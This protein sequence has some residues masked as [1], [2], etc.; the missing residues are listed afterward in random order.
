MTSW[1]ILKNG[2][3]RVYRRKEICARACK[4][5]W[6]QKALPGFGG[7]VPQGC[8]HVAGG[9][10]FMP[11]VRPCSHGIYTGNAG[12]KQNAL[13][14][15][16]VREFS[17]AARRRSRWRGLGSVIYPRPASLSAGPHAPKQPALFLGLHRSVLAPRPHKSISASLEERG[18]DTW[19]E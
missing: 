15:G 7:L 17:A 2:P 8:R 1:A 11:F 10:V 14:K 3:I 12:A 5:L 6:R 19:S 9:F 4:G 16:E 18:T 13:H